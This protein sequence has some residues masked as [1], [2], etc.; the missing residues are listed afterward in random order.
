MVSLRQYQTD[1]KNGIYSSWQQGHRN[2]LGVSPTG[3]GKTRTKS[4]IAVEVGEPTVAI[5]HR[6][7]LVQQI[8]LAMAQADL[9]HR[10]IAP[11]KVVSIIVQQH[12]KECGMSYLDQ[13]GRMTVCGVDTLIRRTS[14]RDI[15]QWANTIRFWMVDEAH[16]LL[17]NNKWGTATEMFPHA[18]GVGVTASPIRCDRK[19]L[20]RLQGGVF[21]DMV[22]GPTMRELIDLGY[23]AD[24]QI[25]GPPQSIN[26]DDLRIS[27]NTG[28]IT[29]P[30]MKK[31]AE[32]STLYGDIVEHY[33]K[34]A[35]GKRGITF[36]HDVE[37]AT[38]VATAFRE[39]GVPA[40]AVSAKTPDIVRNAVIDKFRRGEILQLVNVDLFGEGFD[41]PAVEVVSMARRTESLGLY[42]QQFGRALRI[43]DGKTHGIIID[44]VG[45]VK[46]HGLPDAIRGWQLLAEETGRRGALTDP[47]VLPTTNCTACFRTYE[48]I[49]NACPFCGHVEEPASR[50]DPKF[51]DG[52]LNEYGPELLAELRQKAAALNEPFDASRH[53]P[54]HLRDT[55]A[56]GAI[57]KRYGERQVAQAHLQ[58]AISQWAG[59]R[60]QRGMGD[61]EI[62]RRFFHMF[63]IDVASAQGIRE[64]PKIQQL[65][66]R[67]QE[68]Y[69]T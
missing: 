40:E 11:D 44:H 6:Q 15:K 45:N 19:S 38:K 68:N 37:A 59:V 7:E 2:V 65:T 64:I 34:I 39:R 36:V 69:W 62:Y 18:F 22:V 67:I 53:V 61:S 13:R 47:N 1:L 57:R 24:Y 51:V 55:P 26:D 9:P 4:A 33:L 27:K 14:D 52:D 17:S 46:R 49:H 3:S 56:E 66:V 48:R 16:H 5:A 35:P 63:D 31:A 20:H 50:S 12:V 43:F 25:Y 54:G 42:I 23:L 41:V 60:R 10:I 30:S 58:D 21:D 32:S 28:E 29:A 8:S